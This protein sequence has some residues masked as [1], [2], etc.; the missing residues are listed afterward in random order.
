MVDFYTENYNTFREKMTPVGGVELRPL[1]TYSLFDAYSPSEKRRTSASVLLTQNLRLSLR[2]T[3]VLRLGVQPTLGNGENRGRVS[4]KEGT[5]I[6][7]LRWKEAEEVGK[8]VRQHCVTFCNQ[9]NSKSWEGTLLRRKLCF[10]GHGKWKLRPPC[11]PLPSP[12]GNKVI[13]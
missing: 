8:K 13:C 10:K 4:R 9:E 6:G 11:F 7:I 3:S 2:P 12:L 1:N 5:G